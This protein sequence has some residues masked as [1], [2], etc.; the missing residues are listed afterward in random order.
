MRNNHRRRKQ[1]R[2]L[3]LMSLLFA[4]VIQFAYTPFHLAYE[5]HDGISGALAQSGATDAF[6]SACI[7]GHTHD[8]PIDS[9]PCHAVQDHGG[10]FRVPSASSSYKAL[11]AY[12][13]LTE[14]AWF[15]PSLR[16]VNWGSAPEAESWRSVAERC[17]YSRGPPAVV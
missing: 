11:G 16:V 12:G 9:H 4:M 10:E 13:L 2:R 7:H 1:N 5:E 17:S 14:H 8:Q 15:L 6:V 3:S